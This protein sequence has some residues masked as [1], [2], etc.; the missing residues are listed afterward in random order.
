MTTFIPA[1]SNAL[2]MPSP[3]P[4][5]PPVTN[6]V[7]PGRFFMWSDPP[8]HGVAA[9]WRHQQKAGKA[10]SNHI[11]SNTYNPWFV[12]R[13]GRGGDGGRGSFRGGRAGGGRRTRRAAMARARRGVLRA[14]PCHS[15]HPAQVSRC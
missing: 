8:P 4:L 7:L 3:I 12:K 10:A 14:A 11:V 1:P 9:L 2:A 15:R 6:A 13:V 5:A